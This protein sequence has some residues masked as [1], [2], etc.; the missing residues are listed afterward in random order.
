MTE[1]PHAANAWCAPQTR[2]SVGGVLILVLAAFALFSR[3]DLDPPQPPKPYREITRDPHQL[4]GFRPEEFS[5]ASVRLLVPQWQ[6]RKDPVSAYLWGHFS[7]ADK[8]VLASFAQDEMPPWTFSNTQWALTTA[9]NSCLEDKD[10]YTPERFAGVSLP[11]G[12]VRLLLK[13]PDGEDLARLNRELLAA[14]FPG[15]MPRRR[16]PIFQTKSTAG[17]AELVF[18]WSD[19]RLLATCVCPG[20]ASSWGFD[21]EPGEYP[22]HQL[23]EISPDGEF[24]AMPAP[25]EFPGDL[26]HIVRRDGKSAV[27]LG[28]V[29][30]LLPEAAST[31]KATVL[32]QS[33]FFFDEQSKSLLLW[34][35][36]ANMWMSVAPLTG[37]PSLVATPS[38][39]TVALARRKAR[40][41]ADRW[42]GKYHI[43][44]RWNWTREYFH[45]CVYDPQPPSA[46]PTASLRFLLGHGRLE[47]DGDVIK[48]W[49]VPFGLIKPTEPLSPELV[50]IILNDLNRIGPVG[51]W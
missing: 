40:Q 30:R 15:A 7:A 42:S 35:S 25:E 27:R 17:E 28:A 32:F 19:R 21:L 6:A 1:N 34:N 51:G 43:T 50:P 14:A 33:L 10:L 38:E 36:V 24:V 23:S 22:W 12:I 31:P 47:E 44:P 46:G 48:P 2:Q 37:A 3:G 26:F 11:P 8:G 18:R 39:S 29:R 9:L 16:S 45:P 20:E 4:A 5:L 13:R 41:N 49:L